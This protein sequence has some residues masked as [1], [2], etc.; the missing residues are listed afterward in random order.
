MIITIEEW[1]NNN[2]VKTIHEATRSL[3][4]EDLWAIYRRSVKGEC[5]LQSIVS[6]NEIIQIFSIDTYA[7]LLIYDM[8]SNDSLSLSVLQFFVPIIIFSGATFE[9]K[10]EL[11]L[12]LFDSSGIG[13]LN[14]ADFERL[15]I[16]IGFTIERAFRK[17]GFLKELR[18]ALAYMDLTHMAV[19]AESIKDMFAPFREDFYDKLPYSDTSYATSKPSLFVEDF[20]NKEVIRE[21]FM[22]IYE[23]RKQAR[24]KIRLQ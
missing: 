16:C 3:G 15:V 22:R 20:A 6:E 13:I 18:R 12:T 19:N 10:A 7:T 9:S 4:G 17:H 11:L 24:S 23:E 1:R 8:L 14:G 5:D 2:E 21:A